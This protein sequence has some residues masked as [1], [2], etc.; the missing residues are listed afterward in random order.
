[1]FY[2]YVLQSLKDKKLYIGY[3]AD[4]KRR[5][6]E[7]KTGGSVSTKKRLP[8]KLLYYEAHTNKEDARRREKYFKTEKGKS[9]IR[10]MLR[11]ALK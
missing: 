1:M 4:L 8:F 6:E 11:N 5:L 7:H 10:Q 9:T 2:V 3:S